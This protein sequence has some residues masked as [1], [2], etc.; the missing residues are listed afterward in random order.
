MKNKENEIK[1]LTE[2]VKGLEVQIETSSKQFSRSDAP[3]PCINK[4]FNRTCSSS[5]LVSPIINSGGAITGKPWQDVFSPASTTKSSSSKLKHRSERNKKAK[6]KIKK[7]LALT[8][9]QANNLE[10]VK[11]LNQCLTG[12]ENLNNLKKM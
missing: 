11:S 10:A 6:N 1:V 9:V 3:N 7:R 4:D 8:P 2:K 12:K 5:P